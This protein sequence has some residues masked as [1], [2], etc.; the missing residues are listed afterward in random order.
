MGCVGVVVNQL[1]ELIISLKGVSG[2]LVVINLLFFN[3]ILIKEEMEE[4]RIVV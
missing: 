1:Y 3:L 2:V 4:K